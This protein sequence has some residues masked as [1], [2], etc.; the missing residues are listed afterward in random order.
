[1]FSFAFVPCND[2]EIVDFKSNVV[3]NLRGVPVGQVRKVTNGVS[4]SHQ[5]FG[6]QQ[7]LFSRGLSFKT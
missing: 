2:H 6:W 4:V 3:M 7:G 1:M 5:H